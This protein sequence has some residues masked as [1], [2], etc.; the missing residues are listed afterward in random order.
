MI[1]KRNKPVLILIIIAL[2]FLYIS[3]SDGN[4]AVLARSLVRKLIRYLF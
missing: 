1:G 4:Y 3:L 2:A